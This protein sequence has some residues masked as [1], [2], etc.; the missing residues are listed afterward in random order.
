M[1]RR[2]EHLSSEDKL[3]ESGWF[4]LRKRWFQGNISQHLLVPKGDLQESCSDF[5]QGQVAI[6]Q[7]GMAL[8]CKRASIGLI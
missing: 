2:L 3:R 8:G 7:G 1:I 4:S 5:L 6:G